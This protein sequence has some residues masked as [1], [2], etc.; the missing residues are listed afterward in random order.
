MR[1]GLAVDNAILQRLDLWAPIF[2]IVRDE[3]IWNARNYSVKKDAMNLRIIAITDGFKLG[4]ACGARKIGL[5]SWGF[6]FANSPLRPFSIMANIKCQK[7][8]RK[9]G[10]AGIRGN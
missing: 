8:R 1:I 7:S 2:T 4:S 9:E 3:L 5:L 10:N 6:P